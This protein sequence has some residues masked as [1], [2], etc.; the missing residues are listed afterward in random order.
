MRLSLDPNSPFTLGD[1]I[2]SQIRALVLSGALE[3]GTLLPSAR[4]LSEQLEVN[5]NTVAAAYRGLEG[6]GYLL[7]RKRAG[8][9]VSDDP[10]RPA[11][12][13]LAARLT[14]PL[15]ATLRGLGLDGGEAAAL[16]AAQCA[17]GTTSGTPRVAVLARTP[18]RAHELAVQARTLLGHG[19]EF[20]AQ[21]LGHYVSSRFHLTLIDPELSRTLERG[22]RAEATPSQPDEYRHYS[23][24]FP[25]GAD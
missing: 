6:E 12:A 23:P 17:T 5:I 7:Q 10:P 24:D 16:L 22:L 2:A 8:T 19:I 1:Q 13:L 14:A 3:P 11:A 4:S 25:A 15:A 9:R 20:E 21:T 18:L